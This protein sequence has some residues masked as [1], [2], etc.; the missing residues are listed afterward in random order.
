MKFK[1]RKEEFS[2]NFAYFFSARMQ[3]Q[4][5]EDVI[6]YLEKFKD[7]KVSVKGILR[8][9]YDTKRADPMMR[10]ILRFL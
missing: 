1:S 3:T 4:E 2:V 9:L 7:E 10:N 5:I 6:R 8:G